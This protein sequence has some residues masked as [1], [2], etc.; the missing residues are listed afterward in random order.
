MSKMIWGLIENILE[1]EMNQYV[2]NEK[3][4]TDWEP[5]QQ[6]KFS[7][8]NNYTMSWYHID[9]TSSPRSFKKKCA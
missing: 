5:R 6:E 7:H 9:L 4:L 8:K 1:G 3:I 2:G